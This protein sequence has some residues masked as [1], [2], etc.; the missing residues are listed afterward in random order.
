MTPPEQRCMYVCILDT[1]WEGRGIFN[2][3]LWL[4]SVGGNSVTG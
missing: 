4:L 2:E 3:L 1:M